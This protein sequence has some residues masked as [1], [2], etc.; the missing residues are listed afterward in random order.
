MDAEEWRSVPGW[1]YEA[2][3][4]GRIRSKR[5][6]RI[7]KGRGRRHGYLN[8][9]LHDRGRSLE[10]GVHRLVLMAFDRL[11]VPGEETDHIDRNPSN[12]RR[13][14]LQWL[15][16]RLNRDQR[17]LPRADTHANAKLSSADVVRIRYLNDPTLDNRLAELLGVS[18]ET[19]RDARTGKTW[20][21]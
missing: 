21:Q 17:I 20:R 16:V 12:N 5:T 1:P 2:S 13:D 6:G 7:I 9:N 18:R 11:P 3:D 10:T 14:N 8:V 19:I 15:T 4:R